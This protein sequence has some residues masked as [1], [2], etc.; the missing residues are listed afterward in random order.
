MKNTYDNGKNVI[1]IVK[2]LES[3][4]ELKYKLSGFKPDGF[5]DDA[6]SQKLAILSDMFEEDEKLGLCDAKSN[7]AE[8]YMQ[9]SELYHTCGAWN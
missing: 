9:L 6:F 2:E 8:A 5:G 3:E 4:V 7:R 1:A